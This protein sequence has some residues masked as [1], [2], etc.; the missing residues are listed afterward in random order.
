MTKLNVTQFGKGPETALFVHCSLAHGGVWKSVVGPLADRV[1]GFAPDMPGHGRSAPWDGQGDVHDAVTAG[2]RPLL[3]DGCHLVGHSFGATVALRLALEAP[4]TVRSLTLIEP[5]LFAAAKG[6]PS[7]NSYREALRPY[8]EAREA[9][10]WPEMALA[11]HIAWG[12]GLPWDAIPKP[13]QEAMVGLMPMVAAS[14]ASLTE[15]SCGLLSERRLESL[16][17]PVTFLRG[18]QSQP[19]M[20]QIHAN[21]MSRIS[22]AQEVVVEEAGHMLPISHPTDVSDALAAHLTASVQA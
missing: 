20:A 14:E 3:A 10:D 15:D 6:A 12:G 4:D 9:Q 17:M 19:V 22:Q 16:T 18:G 7:Y 1:T 8:L 5:V 2:V 21:L 11:F 13:T